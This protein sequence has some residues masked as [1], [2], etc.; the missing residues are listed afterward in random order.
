MRKI[1]LIA[2]LPVHVLNSFSIISYRSSVC[3]VRVCWLFFYDCL[4]SVWFFQFL[5][6][7]NRLKLNREKL[8]HMF[9]TQ[10][11]ELSMDYFIV[12]VTTIYFK[13]DTFKK[14][15]TILSRKK[16]KGALKLT[17]IRL[18]VRQSKCCNVLLNCM[19]LTSHQSF[20]KNSSQFRKV[21]KILIEP[22]V[23]SSP[24]VL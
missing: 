6:S 19:S 20:G 17:K 22:N 2:Y 11:M 3:M 5:L 15:W 24:I 23:Y 8:L 16:F 12:N 9:F 4:V 13:K 10:S 1:D 7:P 21:F 14:V 18:L